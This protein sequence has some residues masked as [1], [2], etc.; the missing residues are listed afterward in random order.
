VWGGG[1]GHPAVQVPP[2]PSMGWE[3]TAEN[4]T[5]THA[6]PTTGPGDEPAGGPA[7][8]RPRRTEAR[9]RRAASAR[10]RPSSVGRTLRSAGGNACGPAACGPAARVRRQVAAARLRLTPSQR[11]GLPAGWPLSATRTRMPP[12]AD[13]EREGRF[14]VP[15][16][17]SL[18]PTDPGGW[19]CRA[20]LARVNLKKR[21]R[22]AH[23]RHSGAPARY[24]SG[25]AELPAA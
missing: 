25:R 22:L 21:L 15:S 12:R 8:A 2:S 1:G 13:S 7:A 11:E 24:E 17:T 10:R 6:L 16:S 18:K 20:G 3:A 4:H 19:A 5:R 9:A 14:Q 23:I